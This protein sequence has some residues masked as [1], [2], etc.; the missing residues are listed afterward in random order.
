MISTPNPSINITNKPTIHPVAPNTTTINVVIKKEITPKIVYD[1]TVRSAT[2]NSPVV[3]AKK[4]TITLQTDQNNYPISISN[5]FSWG[6]D[7]LA[8]ATIG[9]TSGLVVGIVLFLLEKW[10]SAKKETKRIINN[11]QQ[12]YINALNNFGIAYSL[13]EW[14][15]NAD[16]TI[17]PFDYKFV[18]MDSETLCIVNETISKLEKITD[19][20]KSNVM[21]TY[22]SCF[23][24]EQSIINTTSVLRVSQSSDNGY[25]I[26]K[27]RLDDII[28]ANFYYRGK[29]LDWVVI[30]LKKY[31][32]KMDY[33]QSFQNKEM[34]K[35]YLFVEN[36][37]LNKT[38]N[39][40][41]EF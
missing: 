14:N 30:A 6:S 20:N 40:E 41:P 10:Y 36:K 34:W 22:A 3:H 2:A 19:L 11:L 16:N 35:S 21:K 24:L 9:V 27:K 18:P 31:N 7:L 1:L 25:K 33:K 37:I 12:E 13:F 15:V 29:L 4:E 26:N 28:E 23:G 32:S 8:P 17:C 38:F 5:G 39:K